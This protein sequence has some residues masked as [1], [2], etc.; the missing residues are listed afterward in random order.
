VVLY[1]GEE[2]NCRVD[3][4][5]DVQLEARWIRLEGSKRVTSVPNQ[6][7]R[8]LPELSILQLLQLLSLS[9]HPHAIV[10][11]PSHYKLKEAA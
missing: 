9:C 2:P 5:D 3:G 8:V 7:G 10:R 1:T 11:L 6:E 4:D